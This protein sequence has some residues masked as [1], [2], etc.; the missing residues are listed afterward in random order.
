MAESHSLSTRPWATGSAVLG[1]V[2]LAVYVTV[3]MLEGNSPFFDVLPW[4]L[5][6]AIA[7]A[8][9]FGGA[10][11]DD[12]RSARN[13]LIGAAGLFGVLGLVSIFSIGFGFLLAAG[14]AVVGAGQT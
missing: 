13:L 9:A 1:V 14:A 12:T 11:T 4:A 7:P 3:M 10:L 6:M 8:L 2:L 5:L